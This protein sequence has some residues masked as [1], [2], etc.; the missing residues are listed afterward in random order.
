MSQSKKRK[1]YADLERENKELRAQMPF[2]LAFAS[3]DLDKAGDVLTASA[4]IV[5]LTGLGGRQLVEPF[6][7]RDGLSAATIAALRADIARTYA[8]TTLLKPKDQ[9]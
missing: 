3:R 7:I 6:A 8:L 2:A 4:C 9:T 5:T 1:S